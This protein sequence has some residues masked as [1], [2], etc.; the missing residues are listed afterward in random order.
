MAAEQ[1]AQKG[2]R[3]VMVC[4]ATGLPV[5]MEFTGKDEG[6][7]NGH[8]GW[9]CLHDD[10]S[11]DDARDVEDFNAGRAPSTPLWNKQGSD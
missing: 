4:K 11:E 10:Y 2:E 8:P 7:S 5:I 1:V 9:L 6:E 3:K